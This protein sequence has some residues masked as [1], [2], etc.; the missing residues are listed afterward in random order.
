MLKRHPQIYMP[1]LKE[2]R[3]FAGDLRDLFEPS[4]SGARPETLEEYLS[5]FDAAGEDQRVGEASP[6]YLRS[7]TAASAIADVQPAAR[8]IA[9]LREPASFVRSLHFQL[10]QN[11]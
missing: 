9:I 1:D 6:S 4:S 5:L 10:V 8:I 3:F 2:P 11:H 7:E